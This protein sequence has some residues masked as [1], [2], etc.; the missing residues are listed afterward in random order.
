[1]GLTD[2]CCPR[3]ASVRP[4]SSPRELNI[5]P[6]PPN[7]RA[8]PLTAAV[9][10]PKPAPA[11]IEVGYLTDV[12]GNLEYFNRWVES[13]GVLRYKQGSDVLELA[14]DNAYFIFGG[15]VQDRCAGRVQ[16]S[17]VK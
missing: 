10:E 11:Q 15:D 3:W 16:C 6:L 14:H 4:R 13:S 2:L 12:E 1:M 7:S 17:G 5:V 9:V 8:G